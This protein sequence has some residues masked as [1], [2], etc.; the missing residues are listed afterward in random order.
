MLVN[1]NSRLIPNKA[2]I[3]SQ[4]RGNKWCTALIGTSLLLGSATPGL[5]LGTSHHFKGTITKACSAGGRSEPLLVDALFNATS[6]VTKDVAVALR[7][8]QVTAPI[9]RSVVHILISGEITG[10][11]KGQTSGTDYKIEHKIQQTIE[12]GSGEQIFQ[13]AKELSRKHTPNKVSEYLYSTL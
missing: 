1:W 2:H 5:A 3:L 4:N 11:A 6:K 13:Y 8:D 10:R 9:R 7:A 12:V